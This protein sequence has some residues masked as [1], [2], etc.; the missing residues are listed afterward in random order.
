MNVPYQYVDTESALS[1]CV[2]ALASAEVI[3]FDT[4]FMREGRYLPELALIGL[5]ADAGVWL[6]DPVGLDLMPMKTL[7]EGESVFVM[8]A[9]SQDLE[10]L[11]LVFDIEPA[12]YFDT[13]IGAA[14]LGMGMPGF[15]KL[16]KKMLQVDLPKGSTLS[17]WLRRPLSEQ[18]LL[19]AANDVYYLGEL[20]KA[21]RDRL[22]D[23][24]RLGWA[25]DECERERSKDRRPPDPHRAWWK[26]RSRGKLRDKRALIAQ[27]VAAW[28]EKQAQA[29]N[30]P[31]NT[32]L[33]ELALQVIVERPPKVVEDFK[34]VRGTDKGF[35]RTERAKELFSVIERARA[36]D[37]DQLKRPPDDPGQGAAGGVVA[38]ALAWTKQRAKEMKIESSL[39]ASRKDVEKFLAGEPSPLAGGWRYEH[40]GS[41]LERLLAGELSLYV[42]DG[43]RLRIEDRKP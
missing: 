3:G 2:K 41:E 40:L 29:R 26:L 36:L 9:G 33:S 5:A 37:L 25:Q 21:Q 23:Q 35:Y 31:P 14:F 24:G 32:I 20:Y 43:A 38:L 7:L 4:E 8:H 12:R 11:Q 17:D 28:R 6:V 42:E 1:A 34:R 22:S 27:E 39:L 13:Q 19:Y 30:K 18:A 15:G 16:I 10:I